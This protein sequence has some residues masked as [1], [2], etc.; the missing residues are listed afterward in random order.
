MSSTTR[1]SILPSCMRAKMSLMFSSLSVDYGGL[2]LA[3]SC[4]VQRLLQVRRVPT[5]EPQ[6]RDALEHHGRSA[7]ESRQGGQCR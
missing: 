6:Y 1:Q 3:L 2:D 4:K 7:A 5:M